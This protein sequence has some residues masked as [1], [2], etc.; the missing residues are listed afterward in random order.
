MASTHSTGCGLQLAAETKL[1]ILKANDNNNI[2]EDNLMTYN[3]GCS[4]YDE[5]NGFD[6]YSLASVP[7]PQE[8]GSSSTAL[9]TLQLRLL[10]SLPLSIHMQVDAT[11]KGNV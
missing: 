8:T 5:T 6:T 2:I 3:V 1:E 10:E 4:K 11:H 7:Q 9:P